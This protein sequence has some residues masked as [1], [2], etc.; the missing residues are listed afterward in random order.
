MMQ[1]GHGGVHIPHAE[2]ERQHYHVQQ[3]QLTQ[4]QIN[5]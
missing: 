4:Q 3:G 5:Q 1:L 2:D